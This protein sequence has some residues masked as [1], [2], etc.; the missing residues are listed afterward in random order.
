M[1]IAVAQAVVNSSSFG[2]SGTSLAVTLTVSAGSTLV[3]WFA[4]ATDGVSTTFAGADSR[5]AGNYSDGSHIHAVVSG[6]DFSAYRFYKTR[7]AAGS[8]T[9]TVTFSNSVAAPMM[10]VEEV[11][12]SDGNAP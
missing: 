12:G 3:V 11:T 6:T 5:N 9:V 8:T 7:C 1:A 2:G 10:W 4:A